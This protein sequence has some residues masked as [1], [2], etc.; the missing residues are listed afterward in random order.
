METLPSLILHIPHSST[1]IPHCVRPT[2][3]LSD[4]QLQSELLRITDA[5]TDE[6]FNADSLGATTVRHAVSRLVVDPE[7]FED[8]SQEP[9][10]RVGMGVIYTR[11]IDGHELRQTPTLA[12]RETLLDAYYRPHHQ[13]LNDATAAALHDH[14]RCL[15]IDC[16]SFPIVPLA[17]ELDRSLDRPDICIGT[18]PFHT[19][20]T[21][22]EFLVTEFEH[23]G[24]TV[25]VN[26][27]FSG[28]L[29]PKHFYRNDT[30]VKSVMIE[31]NRALYMNEKT[32][33]RSTLFLRTRNV[34]LD[35]L[36]QMLVRYWNRPE[37]HR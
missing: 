31:I 33:E 24:Y 15:I 23:A 36:N 17:F 7:R 25:A 11:S 18:D 28:S 34:I 2:L 4:E 35:V 14:G 19:P 13:A 8:D 12:E 20:F 6:L 30:R 1:D 32:G 37:Q 22:A 5:Y 29:V 16:H 27:P 26:R 10:S 9:M 3:L 21:L